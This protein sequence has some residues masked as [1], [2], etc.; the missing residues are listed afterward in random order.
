MGFREP[1][2]GERHFKEES[3]PYVFSWR[4]IG[5]LG[6]RTYGLDC[7]RGKLMLLRSMYQGFLS[8]SRQYSIYE[9]VTRISLSCKPLWIPEEHYKDKSS[10]AR[11]ESIPLHTYINITIFARYYLR[12]VVPVLIDVQPVR[13]AGYSAIRPS[14]PVLA[15]YIHCNSC[16]N[17]RLLYARS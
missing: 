15:G 9:I 11:S 8:G 4:R 3:E 17:P 7:M 13:F 5:Q 16:R 14:V 1:L 12:P 2:E 10:E 6:G